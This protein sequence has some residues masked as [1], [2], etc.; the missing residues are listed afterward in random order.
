VARAR[1]RRDVIA[2]A[3]EVCGDES[4]SGQTDEQLAVPGG[5]KAS[6]RAAR[7]MNTFEFSHGIGKVLVMRV[8][9]PPI[10]LSLGLPEHAR[11]C[12]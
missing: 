5:E 7:C 11:E 3:Q 1:D 2:A 10:E 8:G 12:I 6:K 4:L 9:D